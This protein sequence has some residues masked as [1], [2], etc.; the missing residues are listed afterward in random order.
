MQ[1]TNK[2]K[3]IL[4]V[5]AIQRMCIGSK[6]LDSDIN[7]NDK[8]IS[9][10]GDIY[11]Y[12]DSKLKKENLLKPIRVQLKSTGVEEFSGSKTTFSMGMDDISNYYKEGGTILFVVEVKDID[13]VKVYYSNL[14]PVKLRNILNTMKSKNIKSK[15]IEVLELKKN[16]SREL[17]KVVQSFYRD[18]KKQ[19]KYLVDNAVNIES[20]EDNIIVDCSIGDIVE[21]N[22]NKTYYS[23]KKIEQEGILLPKLD[24]FKLIQIKSNMY[25]KVSIGEKVFF[26]NYSIVKSKDAT[27]LVFGDRI[28]LDLGTSKLN[29]KINSSNLD[30]RLLNY[31]FIELLLESG[32]FDINGI[33][34]ELEKENELSEDIYSDIKLMKDTKEVF[35]ILGIDSSKVDLNKLDKQ[36]EKNL[37]A[38]ID[39]VKYNKA[40]NITPA[41]KTTTISKINLGEEFILIL[42]KPQTETRRAT[43]KCKVTSIFDN[44]FYVNGDST[45][46]ITPYLLFDFES[47]GCINNNLQK[48]VVD[49]KKYEKQEWYLDIL[50]RYVIN[51]INYYDKTNNKKYL[52]T[53]MEV[54]DWMTSENILRENIRAINT[55]LI[56]SKNRDLNIEEIELLKNII[57]TTC[58]KT[59]L[60]SA[61]I[62]LGKYDIARDLFDT[63]DI[64]E[65]NIFKEF[66]IYGLLEDME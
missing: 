50:E 61:N 2:D 54:N 15:S 6:I 11:L 31:E 48:A 7:Y 8:T 23:Y 21:P 28:S 60:I 58:E 22:F 30:N 35:D 46:Q 25:K 24:E 62:L 65:Q 19:S 20:D 13:N 34:L 47:M 27:E 53:A 18:I 43:R 5:H 36:S 66:P 10:D 51:L 4:S 63:L 16:T 52:A 14:V 55:L 29:F 49:I 38:I 42:V 9:W 57:N 33:T 64:S 45:K 56:N 40:I 44:I 59:V 39:S 3:E 41:I 26:E 1:L 37:L 32:K 12:N 17:E